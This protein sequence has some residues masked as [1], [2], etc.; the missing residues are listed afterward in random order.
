MQNDAFRILKV[1]QPQP[2]LAFVI[3]LGLVHLT[4]NQRK[5]EQYCIFQI[6]ANNTRCVREP[7]HPPRILSIW[8]WE[9]KTL[10]YFKSALNLLLYILQQ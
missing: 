8:T 10:A 7:R 1:I 9:R 4:E 5:N 6:N 3:S 2:L